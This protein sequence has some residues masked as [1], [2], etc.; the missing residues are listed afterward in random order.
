MLRA[1]MGVA[2]GPTADRPWDVPPYYRSVSGPWGTPIRALGVVPPSR[3]SV[4]RRDARGATPAHRGR[5]VAGSCTLMARQAGYSNRVACMG[6][7]MLTMG[8]YVEGLDG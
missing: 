6:Y 1:L 7:F 8:G 3:G 2:Q 5:W 4:A